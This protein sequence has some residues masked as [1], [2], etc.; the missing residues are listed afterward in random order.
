MPWSRRGGVHNARKGKAFVGAH[1]VFSSPRVGSD[2]QGC[3]RDT[4]SV[5][6]NA[7]PMVAWRR[8]Q[9]AI[10]GGLGDAND[11]VLRL[12]SDDDS[13]ETFI[14]DVCNTKDHSDGTNLSLLNLLFSRSASIF[15][16][17]KPD[18]MKTQLCQFGNRLVGNLDGTAHDYELTKEVPLRK[19]PPLALIELHANGTIELDPRGAAGPGLS[20]PLLPQHQECTSEDTNITSRPA[21]RT[22]SYYRQD[23]TNEDR[24]HTDSIPISSVA[25]ST[26]NHDSGVFELNSDGERY[27][28]FE[29][30]GVVSRWKLELPN[31]FRQF[32]YNSIADVLFTIQFTSL[33]GG[34][35]WRDEAAQSAHDFRANINKDIGNDGAFL[36]VNLSSNFASE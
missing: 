14:A 26:G 4:D 20:W 12:A 21:S 33:E 25:V 29:G 24:F 23:P 17:G 34:A 7:Q 22:G 18:A 8:M 3:E 16:S 27:L 32:D 6:N 15:E 1:M 19:V 30:A 9:G 13:P 5:P 2:E 28:P 36:L 31:P 10:I 11:H 35:I